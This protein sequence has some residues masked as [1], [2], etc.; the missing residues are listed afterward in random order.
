MSRALVIGASRGIGRE[1]VH[2]LGRD[3]WQVFA[4]ARDDA[5]LA[6]LGSIGAKAIKLDVTQTDSIATIAWQFDGEQF[7]LVVYVAGVYGPDHD[8][9]TAPTKDEFDRVMHANV[10]GAMQLIPTI[11]PMV[12]AARGKFIFI[13]SAMGSID[14]TTSSSGWLYRVSKSALNMVM[15]CASCEYPQALF[16]SMHPGWV[17]T[18]MGGPNATVTAER[19]VA[20]MRAIIDKL[21][22]QDNGNFYGYDGRLLDW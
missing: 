13:S 16:A 17:K 6:A 14:N 4:T 10:L 2:Q 1:F 12:E 8:A 15:K 22:P 21:T 7:D 5:S 19:S 3:G 9:R 11:A 18:D 20:G